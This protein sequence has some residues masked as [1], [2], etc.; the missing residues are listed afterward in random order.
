MVQVPLRLWLVHK[1]P[2]VVHQV[3]E[4]TCLHTVVVVVVLPQPEAVVVAE[5][6]VWVVALVPPLR[7]VV[8]VA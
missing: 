1:G 5:V 8:L 3:L 4:T 2:W 7:P 6:A